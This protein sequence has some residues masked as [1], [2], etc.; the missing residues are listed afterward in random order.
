VN[1][2]ERFWNDPRRMDTLDEFWMR[3][4]DRPEALT[5]LYEERGWM[6]HGNLTD[7]GRARLNAHAELQHEDALRRNAMPGISPEHWAAL[8]RLIRGEPLEPDDRPCFSGIAL[9]ACVERGPY[10]FQV[11]SHGL[12]LH[13]LYLEKLEP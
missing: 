1:D 8:G 2:Y 5:K 9:S 12:L 6:D 7:A 11:T 3:R 13:R 4:S 10:G